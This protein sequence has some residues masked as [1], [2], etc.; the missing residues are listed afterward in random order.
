MCSYAYIVFLGDKTIAGGQITLHRG[1]SVTN[2]LA[3]IYGKKK[4][5]FSYIIHQIML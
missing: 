2:R 5:G 1:A 3:K 4:D